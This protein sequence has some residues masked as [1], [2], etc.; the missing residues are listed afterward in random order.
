VSEPTAV[1]ACYR[2]PDRETYIRCQRCQRPI[3]PDCM[4]DAAVGYQC[5]ECLAEGRRTTR[6]ARTPYGGRISSSPAITSQV[7]IAINAAVWLAIVLTGWGASAVLRWLALIPVGA[8]FS[9]SESGLYPT[10][11][12]ERVCEVATQ[13]DGVWFPGVADGAVWQLLTSAFTHVEVWH[14]AVNMLVLWF[15]GPQLE[16]VLGR[17]R[18]VVLYLVSALAGSVCVYWLAAE[19]SQTVGASGAIF[20]L[21]GAM[22]VIAIKLG[23]DVQTLLVWLGINAV[24]TFT[25][26]NVS[27][28]GHLGGFIGGALVALVI[29]YA[30][31]ERRVPVQAAGIGVLVAVLVAA[32]VARTLVLI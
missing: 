4:T 18:Y 1:P 23:G 25:V 5:P 26:P 14:I 11:P 8:C 29:V 15:V 6:S 32:T 16:R 10:V 19:H 27:W 28:Q 21:L 3:C 7:I 24:I 30:P 22:L 9:R 31:R 17:T 2:H 12:S 20:G 13:G